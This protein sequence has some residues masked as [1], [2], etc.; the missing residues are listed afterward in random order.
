VRERGKE[1]EGARDATRPHPPTL[2][3]RARS[4]SPSL[5]RP[6][7]LLELAPSGFPLLRLGDMGSTRAAPGPGEQATPYVT[8]RFYRPPE[9]LCGSSHYGPAVDVWSLA[10]AFARVR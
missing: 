9:L 7:L 1:R 4:R 3:P 5:R 2:P 10:C 8:S 6:N